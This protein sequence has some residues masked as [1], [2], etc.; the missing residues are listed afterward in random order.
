MVVFKQ[1]FFSFS[2]TSSQTSYRGFAPGPNWGPSGPRDPLIN[3]P[4]LFLNL[5]SAP[6]ICINTVERVRIKWICLPLSLSTQIHR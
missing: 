6:V 2:E 5:R 4:P 3:V 1:R